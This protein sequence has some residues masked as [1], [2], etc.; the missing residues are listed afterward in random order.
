MKN[1]SVRLGGREKK[2]E[3]EDEET[4]DNF[5]IIQNTTKGKL[6]K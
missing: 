4:D 1:M 6:K 5:K 2:K 3:K